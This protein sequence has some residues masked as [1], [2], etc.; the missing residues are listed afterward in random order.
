M[1]LALYLSIKYLCHVS[2]RSVKTM[3][4]VLTAAR[5]CTLRNDAP[6]VLQFVEM[7]VKCNAVDYFSEIH[8][9]LS[10]VFG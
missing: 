8:A 3:P 5:S 9:G 1:Y 4:C 10:R 6:C 2:V 7:P